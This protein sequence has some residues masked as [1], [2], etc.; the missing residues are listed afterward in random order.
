MKPTSSH[1]ATS[2]AWREITQSRSARYRFAASHRL[3]VM[4][5][6]DVIGEARGLASRSPR[7]AKNWK[8]PTRMWLDATRVRTAPGNAS[9]AKPV[10]PVVTA[11]SA[12]VVGMPSAAIASLTIYSRRTGPSAARPSPPPR[13]RRSAGPLELDVAAHAVAVDHF[14]EQNG[15]SVTELR[16]EGPNWWPA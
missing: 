1:F 5:R 9:R 15:A 6:D 10:S 8:V 3:W 16:Y 7:A 2:A 14:A 13:K 12:R 4:P 11:A